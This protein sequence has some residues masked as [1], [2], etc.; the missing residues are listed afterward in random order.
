[1]TRRTKTCIAAIVILTICSLLLNIIPIA[2]IMYEAFTADALVYEKVVFFGSVLICVILTIWT[3][4]SRVNIKSKYLVILCGLF[5]VLENVMPFIVALT[6]AQLL[7]EVI[8]APLI[9]YYKEKRH[10]N[11]ELD[12]RE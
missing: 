3:W 7:D 2:L 11:A 6:I 8:F 9:K 1:M 4:F 12:R 10:I 5:F